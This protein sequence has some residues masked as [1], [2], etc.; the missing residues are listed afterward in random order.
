MVGYPIG[1]PMSV[2]LEYL[3]VFEESGMYSFVSARLIYAFESVIG[4]PV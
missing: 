1:I 3:A 2:A 4:N